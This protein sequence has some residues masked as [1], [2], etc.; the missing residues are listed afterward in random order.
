MH[1]WLH[2]L[3][4]AKFATGP[5]GLITKYSA[6]AR[7][8]ATCS[9]GGDGRREGVTGWGRE[10]GFWVGGMVSERESERPVGLGWARG[11]LRGGEGVGK[12]W[13]SRGG[14]NHR[15]SLCTVRFGV[16]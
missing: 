11:G 7:N 4:D 2:G 6:H 16:S 8:G 1:I 13:G 14:A 3:S 10:G 9:G 5:T 12:R 15:F